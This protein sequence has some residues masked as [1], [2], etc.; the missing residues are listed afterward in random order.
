VKNKVFVIAEA[1][2]NHNGNIEIAKKLI[3]AAKNSD[4]DAVKFQTFKAEKVMSK[5]AQMADY[6]KVNTGIDETQL[7][8]IKKLELS[9]NDFVYLKEY[10]DK[11]DI[12]FM[13]TPFDYDSIDF[14]NELDVQ[15][16]KIPSGEITNLPYL[17]KIAKLHK[18]VILS[19]GMSTM[20]DIQAALSILREN[21]AGKI[22]VLHCTTE[23]P[24]P[25]EDVN[26]NAMNTI[27]KEFNVP[28]GYSDHTKG[29]E[30]P[31]AAVALGAT[32]IEKHFTLDRNMEG[33]DHKASLEPD[34]LK[35]MV[36]AIR[37]VED[38][39]GSGEKKPAASEQ[40]NM[41][42]ARKS[43]VA[44]CK[45]KK[46][47]VFTEENIAVKRP[48]DGISPM[49]WFEVIGQVAIRDFEED[50]LIEL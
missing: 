45:I 35:A 27:K 39:L 20:E 11:L 24:A 25:F 38:S 33:P 30:I 41:A 19:T 40:K 43:I 50:E 26:L 46:S 14:L 49:K 5:F 16:W 17:I 48:G 28:V 12:E 44:N 3:N 7:E 8:M 32:I 2:V 15:H 10:C 9:Y 4:A 37:N 6:Q 1:G 29:I 47:E 34:E 36:S 22:T 42:I 13:S 18:P 23:Y 31:I 21:G